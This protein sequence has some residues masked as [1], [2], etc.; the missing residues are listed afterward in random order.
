MKSTILF[1]ALAAFVAV[2]SGSAIKDQVKVV[3]HP[4]EDVDVA[5]N[6][7]EDV[8]VANNLIEDVAVVGDPESR[9]ARANFALGSYRPGDRLL[10]S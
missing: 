6:L 5:S 1:L 8:K 10:S 2:S 4:V 9:A 7:I 3:N